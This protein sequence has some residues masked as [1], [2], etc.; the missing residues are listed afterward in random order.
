MTGPPSSLR[1]DAFEIWKAGVAAVDSEALIRQHVQRDGNSLSIGPHHIDLAS[2]RKIAVVGAGKAAAGMAVALEQVL[3]ADCLT[4][5]EVVGWVNVPDNC[6]LPTSTIHLHAAR[7]AG[8]NEPRP[9]GVEGAAE[10]LKLVAGL[11]EQDLCIA[12]FSGGGSALLP[13]PRPG[14]TLEDKIEVTRHLSA[15]GANIVEL[16]TVRQHMSRIKGGGLLHACRAGRLLTLILS[17]VLGDPLDLIAS[18]PTVPAQTSASDAVEILQRYGAADA[19]VDPR[20]LEVLAAPRAEQLTSA[21]LAH[22]VILGNNATAVEAAAQQARALGYHPHS[23]AATRVEGPA[24]EVGRTLAAQLM[25]PATTRSHDCWISGGEP[26]VQ[27]APPDVRGRG[28]RNQQ[29]V[30]AALESLADAADVALLSAGTDGEDGPTDAAGAVVD[31]DVVAECRRQDLDVADALARNDAYTFFAAT[32]GLL[33]TGP[34]Q[35]NVCDLRV[36]VRRR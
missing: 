2:T 3:G 13:A 6:L 7:P 5:H 20:V 8:V 34:T 14:L 32:G 19:G 16:N 30:L 21:C 4:A 1:D 22:E 35:T 28:G 33:I 25:T 17:D 29:L 11:G 24:E 36:A 23:E 10:M 31:A 27:L 26:T 15:A 9:E 12:L 18:G